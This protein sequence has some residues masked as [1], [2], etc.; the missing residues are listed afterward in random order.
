[1][2][3]DLKRFLS[4]LKETG[5]ADRKSQ[6]GICPP[7]AKYHICGMPANLTN[8]HIYDLRNCFAVRLTLLATHLST[9]LS[10]PSL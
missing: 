6:F 7:S 10:D 5:S 1:M 2:C 3:V 4:P 8:L 9:V